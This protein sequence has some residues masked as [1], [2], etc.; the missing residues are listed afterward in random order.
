MEL[1][2]KSRVV[3]LLEQ[4]HGALTAAVG[5][6]GSMTELGDN[7]LAQ[8]MELSAGIAR[9]ADTAMVRTVEAVNEQ[10]RLAE[11]G[12][13]LASRYGMRD[14]ATLLMAATGASRRTVTRWRQVGAATAPR[15][16]GS[17]GILPP[18]FPHMAEALSR[19]AVSLDQSLVIRQHVQQAA[20]RAHPDDLDAAER[21]LVASA[22]GFASHS[23]DEHG[24]E[25][26]PHDC[27]QAEAPM[28]PE[29]LAVQ[30]RAWRD[31]IDCDGPEP[32]Y[33]ELRRQRSFTFGQ[34][35]DGMWVGRLLLPTD[36]GEALRLALDAHNAPRTLAR[37]TEDPAASSG[38]GSLEAAE[39]AMGPASTG[40]SATDESEIRTDRVASQHC[41]DTD[42]GEQPRADHAA[43][44]E[45]QRGTGL[46]RRGQRD[47]RTTA[48]RQA[49]TLVGLISAAAAD[50]SS[51]RIGGE[52]A[53]LMVTITESELDKHAA[54]QRGIAHLAS[55]GE[56]VPAHVAA[57]V[58][59]DGYLQACVLDDAG[60]PLKLGR[61]RRSHTRHQRRAILAA[62]PGGCQNAGCHAPPGFTE[63]HHPVW[64][65]EGGTTD[66]DN[67]I[68]L[69][70]HCHTEVHAGRLRCVRDTDGR[71]R[72]A[73]TLQLRQ[74]DWGRLTA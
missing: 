68:P 8:A 72:A 54:G 62:Y 36:Q 69:C 3:E 42:C 41:A 52:A 71:W 48:Q 67:G 47:D 7:A 30:A 17:S 60:L 9:L 73:P 65:S 50:A 21:A 4:A 6:V 28:S 24:D 45:A 32:A 55:T 22:V 38:A 33:E 26:P 63:I 49:D 57:R 31:A 27:G 25:P 15:T 1:T 66:T 44:D 37:H 11:P 10:A 5:E 56:P 40:A 2:T 16:M 64:W 14:A 61:A 46:A 43:V 70:Q 74:W 20:P 29:L 58:L 59:C 19:G 23:P 39:A 35:T 53:T 13:A 18:L 12:E 51:P 34:R